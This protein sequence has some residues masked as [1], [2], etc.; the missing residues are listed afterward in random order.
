MHRVKPGETLWGL[1]RRYGMTVRGLMEINGLESA[2]LKIG[3]KLIV[4]PGTE[5]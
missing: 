2:R 5:S 3:Q 1:A 4:A